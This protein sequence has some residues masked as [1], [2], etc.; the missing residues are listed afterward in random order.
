MRSLTVALDERAYDIHI[1]RGLI[2]RG[3]LF[4]SALRRKRAVII[5]NDV[6]APLYAARVQRALD[7]AGVA[8]QLVVLPDG[9]A[10]KD[11]STLNL[12]FDAL[13][14][15]RVE[16]STTLIALGGGVI[17]DMVG[18]AAATYQ[19]GVPFIQVP[20][21]LLSQVDSSVGGKTA[22]NHPLGKNMIGAFHQPQAGAGRHRHPGYAARSRTARRAGR[23]DQVR[24]DP[25]PRPSSTGSKRTCRACWRATPKRSPLPSSAPAAT[26]PR[27]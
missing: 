3:D 2:D 7:A 11:W 21:T 8:H 6:V 14:G 16:R 4:A 18:F 17:G 25:R 9:E 19:R 27:W 24:P 22:I 12:I 23:S 10:H 20:T 15:A 5:S 13:L 1:G 26:R